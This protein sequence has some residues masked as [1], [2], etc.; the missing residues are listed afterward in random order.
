MIEAT[1][2]NL[3][4]IL[5]MVI[6]EKTEDNGA[7][8][9]IGILPNWFKSFFLE[10][11]VSEKRIRPEKKSPFLENFLIDAENFWASGSP[12]KLNSGPWLETDKRSGNDIAFEAI[13][14][15][16][17]KRKIL[18]IKE[19]IF[20]YGEKQAV[21]Q[22]GRELSLAY[23]RLAQTESE[24]QKAKE[25]AEK[26]NQAKSEFLANMSH[27]IR[28]P[29]TAIIGLTDMSISMNPPK[30]Q[31]DNLDIIKSS[32]QSLL[33]VINDI[34][35]LSKIEAKKL[36]FHAE[37]FDFHNAMEKI[38]NTF[39]LQAKKKG[40]DLNLHIMPDVPKYLNGDAGVSLRLLQIW[41]V[42]QS[43]L[44]ITEVFWLI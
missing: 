22:K 42:M 43:S 25:A 37:D 30:D 7:F 3:L 15:S 10:E 4:N 31:L 23:Y 26:A 17:E 41:S 20:S 18:L 1:L 9:I 40:L 21:I 14:V 33:S 19:A 6:M 2:V 38:I 8:Q 32:A 27:E 36:E 13:A 24:L 12:G 39:S 34:L 29:I 11:D 35:D 16:L 28:T 44:Q 5:D